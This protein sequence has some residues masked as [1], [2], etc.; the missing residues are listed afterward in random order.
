MMV[1]TYKHLKTLY[2]QSYCTI[3]C[4]TKKTYSLQFM[5]FSRAL[6]L[7][8]PFVLVATGLLTAVVFETS[9]LGGG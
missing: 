2:L 1:C 4:L 7:N 5:T 6:N 8:L 9:C 3:E